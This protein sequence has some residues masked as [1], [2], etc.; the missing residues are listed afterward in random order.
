[1][2]VVQ[3]ITEHINGH[4]G[5]FTVGGGFRFHDGV[6]HSLNSLISVGAIH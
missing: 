1:M 4:P 6:K 3:T 5:G 2:G